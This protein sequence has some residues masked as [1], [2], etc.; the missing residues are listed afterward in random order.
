MALFF[1]IS[2]EAQSMGQIV[3]CHGRGCI[4][5]ILRA[6]AGWTFILLVKCN[7]NCDAIPKKDETLHVQMEWNGNKEEILLLAS[8]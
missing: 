5:P 2:G 1:A 8:K 7:K 4:T 3:I 6:N